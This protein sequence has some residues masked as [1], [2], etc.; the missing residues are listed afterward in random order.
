MSRLGED[1]EGGLFRRMLQPENPA[2]LPYAL[3]VGV[4]LLALHLLLQILFSNA[5][6]ILSGADPTNTRDVVKASL[7]VVLPASLIVFAVGWWLAGFRGGVRAEVLNMRW[8]RFTLLGWIVVIF[9][10]IVLMYCAIMMIVLAL[11]IDLSQY[12]PGPN[13]QSPQSGSAGLVK[14]AMFDIANEPRLFFI[15]LPSVAIG[16]PL[17]EEMI[18]RGQLFTALSATRL[19]ASG[20]TLLTAALWSLLHMTEPWLS[21]GLVFVMGLIFG[22]LMIRF[23]SIW[24]TM[25]CHGAW[26]GAYALLIFSNLGGGS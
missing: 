24:V 23:G 2:G 17:A 22:C 26:N 16:A 6:V 5:A 11:G 9:G 14:E 19:G 7:A 21:I 12:T 4:G 10:F 8:P 25:I 1:L 18:F 15:I 20:A 3:A 13:G